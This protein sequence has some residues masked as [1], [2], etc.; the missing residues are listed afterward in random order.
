MLPLPRYKLHNAYAVGA[1][2]KLLRLKAQN[3]I[4]ESIEEIVKIWADSRPK[5]Y[6][7]FVFDVTAIKETMKDKEYGT[8]GVRGSNLRRY[9]DIPDTVMFMIR[10]LYTPE[11][12]PMD[13]NFFI[14]W[15]KKFPK[16]MVVNK[17]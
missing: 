4:W 3:K 1:A 7:S 16:M 5:E 2:E 13:K 6:R 10:K 11:E 8:T 17:I 15:S 14:L 12:L 9:L